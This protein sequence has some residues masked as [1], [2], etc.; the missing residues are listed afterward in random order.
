MI[1]LLH[2]ELA[3]QHLRLVPFSLLRLREHVLYL[4]L[5]ASI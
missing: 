2:G 4:H 5:Q 1:A 3:F